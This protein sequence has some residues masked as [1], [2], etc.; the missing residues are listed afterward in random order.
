MKLKLIEKP[1]VEIRKRVAII[2]F[3]SRPYW[4]SATEEVKKVLNILER[5]ID[6]EEAI[7][8]IVNQLDVSYQEAAETLNE[9]Q[10]LLFSNG[11]L[12]VDNKVSEKAKEI[13]PH[14]QVNVTER[15][16]VIAA[17]QKCNLACLHCYANAK[18]PLPYEL[19]MGDFKKLI[20]DLASMPWKNEISSI[21]LT[22]GEFF[23]RKDAM[24]IID[25][26]YHYGFRMLISTNGLML[27]D[28]IIQKI[29]GYNDLKISISLDGPVA[30]I[31]ENIRGQGTFKPTIQT[32]RKLTGMGVFV[33][34]NMF[35]HD[36]NLDLIEDT[37]LLA[38]SLGAKAF[39]CINLLYVGRANSYKSRS[40]LVRVPETILYRKLFSILKSNPHYQEMMQNS[41]FAN[42]IM[43]IAGGIKSHYCGIGTNRALYVMADGNIYPCPHTAV[44]RFCLGNTRNENLKDIWEKSHILKDLRLLDVDKMNSKCASCDVRYFCG[45]SCRGENYQVTKELQSP[46]F[47]CAEIRKTVLEMIWMLTE[48][49]ELFHNKVES[50]YQTVCQ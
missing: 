17:T 10:E 4:F 34:V 26:V 39:N 31:H 48:E 20:D 45:G 19:N 15:V 35:V 1:T 9:I 44:K 41:T 28:E 25:Y 23:T 50:L 16:L 32:V 49:P 24:D 5:E 22:G 27:T 11:V 18:K 21:G 13:D 40:K 3:P 37:I 7:K 43:G 29:A 46:H 38:D 12:L 42:Q 6:T 33:G 30:E 2:I 14:F 47:N 8:S 36:G